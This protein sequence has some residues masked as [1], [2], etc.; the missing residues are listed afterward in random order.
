MRLSKAFI[1]IASATV[2]FSYEAVVS[3]G[4]FVGKDTTDKHANSTDIYKN[5]RNHATA[6]ASILVHVAKTIGYDPHTQDP[7][8]AAENFARFEM[9]WPGLMGFRFLDQAGI[10]LNF[11]S[12]LDDLQRQIQ[13]A[14][15]P[16]ANVS[17]ARSLCQLVPTSTT[18][19]TAKVWTL[20][21]V[22]IDQ[23]MSSGDTRATLISLSLDLNI[24]GDGK[25]SLPPQQRAAIN[26]FEIRVYPEEMDAKAAEFS[27]RVGMTTTINMF[28]EYFT[29]TS[30]NG[31]TLP[32]E[33]CKM[34]AD[35]YVEHDFVIIFVDMILHKKPVYRHLLFN[36]LPYRDF[37]IDP[38]VFKL[39]VLLVLFDVYIKWFRL[40][41]QSA[42]ID[43][44]GFAQHS[45]VLQYL[46]ILFL[47]VIEFLSFHFGVRLIV[48]LWY[49][50]R[51]AILKYNYITTALI[52]SSFGKM[53]MMLM[54]IWDYT[55]L[56]YSWLLINLIVFTS[57]IEAL[58]ACRI[59]MQIAF[60]QIMGDSPLVSLTSM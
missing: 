16:Y 32:D 44:G 53:L 55:E 35:K 48:S 49:G 37:G 24:A 54:V 10:L 9:R 34:L 46:Y 21:L 1:F 42:I 12:S 11:S 29:T 45:L 41:Q 51:Y 15:D 4:I 30:G 20:S 2:A 47:C 58:S 38:N 18:I 26:Y 33:H 23:T 25:V 3:R 59:L 36:R 52:I 39:G 13:L 27:R 28:Q 40:E 17:V 5:P 31:L 8:K 57:N 7:A 50:S 60:T 6:A 22:T 43:V 56:E 19:R 14:Y